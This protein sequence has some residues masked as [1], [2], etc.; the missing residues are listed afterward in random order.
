MKKRLFTIFALFLLMLPLTACGEDKVKVELA[1]QK[2]EGIEDAVN[3]ILSDCAEVSGDGT[4]KKGENVTIRVR[5]VNAACQFAGFQLEGS[6]QFLRGRSTNVQGYNGLLKQEEYTFSNISENKKVKVIM[7]GQEES[8]VSDFEVEFLGVSKVEERNGTKTAVSNYKFPIQ[9]ATSSPYTVEISIDN[10]SISGTDKLASVLDSSNNVDL[11]YIYVEQSGEEVL[12]PYKLKWEQ[13]RYYID[14]DNEVKCS[15]RDEDK[16]EITDPNNYTL[17]TDKSVCVRA[18][19]YTYESNIKQEAL[20]NMLSTKFK[21]SINSTTECS[22]SIGTITIGADYDCFY[23][24]NLK[25]LYNSDLDDDETNSEVLIGAAAKYFGVNNDGVIEAITTTASGAKLY[26]ICTAEICDNDN[27]NGSTVNYPNNAYELLGSHIQSLIE[28]I[29]T[30]EEDKHQIADN[31]ISYVYDPAINKVVPSLMEVGS[32]KYY[33]TYVPDNSYAPPKKMIHASVTHHYFEVTLDDVDDEAI[34]DAVNELQTVFNSKLINKIFENNK[35][36][37]IDLLGEVRQR[38]ADLIDA[39]AD[40]TLGVLKNYSVVA[41]ATDSEIT[42]S[43]TKPTYD[44]DFVNSLNF[45]LKQSVNGI[46]Q[47]CP[48]IHNT[49][50]TYDLICSSLITNERREYLEQLLSDIVNNNLHATDDDSVLYKQVQIY[51]VSDGG[52]KYSFTDN[53]T[54]K[55]IEVIVY[56]TSNNVV[57]SIDGVTYQL[58]G[59]EPHSDLPTENLSKVLIEITIVLRIYQEYDGETV[60]SKAYDMDDT[61]VELPVQIDTDTITTVY[62][63]IKAGT[64]YQISTGYGLILVAS[65]GETMYTVTKVD[66]EK[67]SIKYNN[68]TYEFM[69]VPPVEEPEPAE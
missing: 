62:D 47:A 10:Y 44:S 33:F 46:E 6:T 43:F 7:L 24:E 11:N 21:A 32:D 25:N 52:T 38:V 20:N 1:L 66:D 63:L 16:V 5:Y 14:D 31:K 13:G 37:I 58:I 55:E 2:Q 34:E 65:D 36:A 22:A 26:H 9:G 61:E 42:I 53:I 39:D 4:Y 30:D 3:F 50:T 29:D 23:V 18:T 64:I 49:E 60:Q 35:E 68:Y 40:G 17:A 59:L 15:F 69:I 8:L 56:L 28:A 27:G 57:F 19:Y 45:V 67:Y 41:T 12:V 54:N 51:T 48:Y